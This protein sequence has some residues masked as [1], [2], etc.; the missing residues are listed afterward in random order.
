[1]NKNSKKTEASKSPSESEVR[2]TELVLPTHTNSLG[3]VFGGTVMAWIDIAGAIAAGRHCRSIVV[4]ASIDALHFIAPIKEGQI[5]HIR[6]SVN[7]AGTTSVEVGVRVDSEDQLTGETKHNVTAYVTF[8]ALDENG[9]PKPVPR[10][11]AE[12]PEEKRRMEQALIRRKSRM[13]LAEQLKKDSAK[14]NR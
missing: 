6:A 7:F 2:M 3:G 13:A 8:V 9:K 11:N 12:T 4:T 10:V 1:M 5:A 14:P